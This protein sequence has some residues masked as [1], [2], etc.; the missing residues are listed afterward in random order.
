VK[1]CLSL[2]VISLLGLSAPAQIITPLPLEPVATRSAP[3][4]SNPGVVTRSGV[5][6]SARMPQGALPQ[7]GL[8][9]GALPSAGL[10][11]A[12]ATD[13]SRQVP[14]GGGA[15]PTGLGNT[16]AY[17]YLTHPQALPT[18][19]APAATM[20]QTV[21]ATSML[22][23]RVLATGQDDV[24]VTLLKMPRYYDAELRLLM[25]EQRLLGSNF[26]AGA[27]INLGKLQAGEIILGMKV[28]STGQVYPTGPGLRNPDGMP[29]AVVQIG[30][31]KEAPLVYVGYED[32]MTAYTANRQF[33]DAV[34]QFSGGVVPAIMAEAEAS[35]PPAQ[36]APAAPAKKEKKKR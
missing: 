10:P 29:H 18:N 20:P 34:M 9:R 14:Q 1:R 17:Y 26:S 19:G 16:K 25:P 28:N 4:Y 35:P 8:P 12:S 5:P 23:G 30:G 32:V 21:A 33:N 2:M 15:L 3:L 13:L 36:T 27:T 24:I 6:Q 22:G 7:G 31:T 11:N